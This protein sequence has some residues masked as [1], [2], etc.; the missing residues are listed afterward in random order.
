[1]KEV[2]S[3]LCFPTQSLARGCKGGWQEENHSYEKKRKNYRSGS[4]LKGPCFPV[5]S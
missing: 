1:M 4:K 5:L 2:K 3:L